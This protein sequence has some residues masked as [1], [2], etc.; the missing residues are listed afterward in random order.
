MAYNRACRV[1]EVMYEAFERVLYKIF[2][3]EEQP[4]IS[5]GLCDLASEESEVVSLA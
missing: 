1:H 5:D 4:S 3:N 2:L